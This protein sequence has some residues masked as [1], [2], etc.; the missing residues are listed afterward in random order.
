[1]YACTYVC[2]HARVY[3]RCSPVQIYTPAGQSRSR[4]AVPITVIYQQFYQQLTREC[5]NQLPLLLL[6][7]RHRFT[8]HYPTHWQV[9]HQFFRDASDNHIQRN[10]IQLQG[11]AGQWHPIAVTPSLV[12]A[13]LISRLS[14]VL[15][16]VFH[17]RAMPLFAIIRIATFPTHEG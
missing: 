6:L 7:L 15:A 11:V 3:A 9:G 1:M 5:I 17:F 2:M 14:V 12:V 16:R 4:T 10:F 8:M 13:S